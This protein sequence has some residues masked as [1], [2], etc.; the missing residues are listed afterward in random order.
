MKFRCIDRSLI[1][2][3][4]YM[5]GHTH[6]CASPVPKDDQHL[7]VVVHLIDHQDLVSNPLLV[8][9]GVHER[10]KHKELLKALP[11]GDDQDHLVGAP[12]R[13]VLPRSGL[14]VGAGLGLVWASDPSLRGS[15]AQVPRA[16]QL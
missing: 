13:I 8:Q 12:G 9:E 15:V 3:Y 10:H 2:V 11:E 7:P 5:D 14:L 4:V 1:A 16:A 6:A